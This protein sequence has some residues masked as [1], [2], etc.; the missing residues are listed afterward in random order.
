MR[1]FHFSAVV[2]WS[3]ISL[4]L[5]GGCQATQPHTGPAPTIPN[6]NAELVLYIS[7][8]P[9]LTAEPAYRAVYALAHGET[10]NGKFDELAASLQND[11]LIGAW[12]LPP[13]KHLRRMHVGYMICRAVNIRTGVNWNLT[14][15]GRYAWRELIYHEIAAG[16]SELGLISGGEFV[17]ILS[18]AEEYLARTQPADAST[19]ELGNAQAD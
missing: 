12:N 10:F 9:Y 19:V 14:G 16:G 17:G 6:N 3:A 15:L 4:A 13:Q 18:R 7:N 1:A 2:A 8:Q 5:L 11:K